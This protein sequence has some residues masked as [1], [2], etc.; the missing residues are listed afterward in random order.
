[1]N[2]RWFAAAICACLFATFGFSSAQ[3]EIP[4]NEPPSDAQKQQM[5]DEM[6][7]KRQEMEAKWNALPAEKKAEVIAIGDK[8]AELQRQMVDQ[9][10][11]LGLIDKSAAEKMKKHIDERQAGQKNGEM[12]FMGFKCKKRGE[13]QKP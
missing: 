11:A 6:M 10:L 9:Y 13:S 4:Q 7:Q 2:K 12:P 5:R 1:M 3:A 8:M